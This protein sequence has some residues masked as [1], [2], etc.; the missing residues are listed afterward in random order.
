MIQ[1][2]K[3]RFVILYDGDE[4]ETLQKKMR[5][6][7]PFGGDDSAS[8]LIVMAYNINI[9]LQQPL[10]ESCSYLKEYSTLVDKIKS[11]VTEGLIRREATIQAVNECIKNGVMSGYLEKHTEDVFNM[12]ALE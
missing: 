10:L 9:G 8:E 3:P 7:E 5:L 2:P 12:L 6:S 11:G 4:D 1:F